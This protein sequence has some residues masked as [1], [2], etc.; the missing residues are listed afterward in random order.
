[1]TNV[2]TPDEANVDAEAEVARTA[3][4]AVAAAAVAVGPARPASSETATCTRAQAALIALRRAY[5]SEALATNEATYRRELRQALIDAIVLRE[6]CAELTSEI[7]RAQ[8]QLRR[9]KQ[10]AHG[11]VRTRARAKSARSS[12]STPSQ[13][14]EGP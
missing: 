12:P 14:G 7:P 1:M 10:R 9:L 11:G 6:E 2:E 4:A 13:P 8:K 3:T 5:D